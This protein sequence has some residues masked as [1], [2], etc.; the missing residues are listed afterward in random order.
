MD[1]RG[2]L[3]DE[4]AAEDLT[5]REQEVLALLAERLTNRE[6]AARLNL[7]ESTVKEHVSN[8]LGKL[9]VKNR[10]QAVE[11]A[12]AL[13]LLE[14]SATAV[15]R[16]SNNLPAPVTSFIGREAEMTQ[17]ATLLDQPSIRLLT[18]TG[19]PGTG[20]TRL[21]LQAAVELL[22]NYA[23]GVFFVPLAPIRQP[24]LLANTIAK[25][26]GVRGISGRTMDKTLIAYL[27]AKEMLLLLDNFEHVITAAPLVASLLAAVP[28]LKVLVTSRELLHL[29]G[30]HELPVG[31]LELPAPTLNE[32][33]LDLSQRESVSLFK[34]RAMAARPDFQLTDKNAAAVA[35]IC[36]KLDG[37][38]L[39]IELAAARLKLFNPEK[40]VELVEDSLNALTG[41]PLDLPARQQTLRATID[42]S[43]DLL[44]HDEKK[45]FTRLGVFLGGFTP[46]AVELIC[47]NDLPIETQDTLVS[48]LDK[49]L[50]LREAGLEGEPR[51]SM[52]ETL[53]DYAWAGVQQSGEGES[54]RRRHA[55]Y[56][57]AL[58]E[59][60]DEELRGPN[61]S[62]WLDRLDPE[63]NNMRGALDWS[64]GG[65]DPELGLRLAGVLGQYWFKRTHY[66]EGVSRTERALGLNPGAPPEFRG[67]A[68]N[69]ASWLTFYAGERL[70]EGKAWGEEALALFGELGYKHD[71]A[72]SHLSVGVHCAAAGDIDNLENHANRALVLFRELDD[73]EGL[74][75]VFTALGEVAR[76]RDRD[77]ERAEI[78][79]QDSLALSRTLDHRYYICANLYNLSDIARQQG[80]YER[81]HALLEEILSLAWKN[82]IR[83]MCAYALYGLAGTLSRQGKPELAARLFGAYHSFLDALGTGAQPHEVETIE[84]NL[85]ALRLELGEAAFETAVGEG[86]AMTEEQAIVYA[87]SFGR[88]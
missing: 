21:A 86:R 31:P 9:Y 46:E 3:S 4:V 72:W 45:L 75:T 44:E 1:E 6:I 69:S 65:A 70:D 15:F 16:P 28:A 27:R 43:Y 38:P 19:P 7:A 42:W 23:H 11:R 83:D 68:L 20:K 50:L 63:H 39:A 18:L 5:W 88:S 76:L 48:L 78:F 37:L 67:R 49:S 30:E 25:V 8:I 56:F 24:D 33:L 14:S 61:Q 36:Y 2:H 81:Q 77:Y 47:G 32:P 80:E 71:V 60:S 52:L 73:M 85:V 64:L 87:L 13:G 57:L 12:R 22:D 82:R 53:R 34:Q 62:Q 74:A 35:K 29:S 79:Y 84:R 51:F 41:G 59:Q 26:L 40:L 17:I 58:A 55:Q 66:I 10:R 54:L